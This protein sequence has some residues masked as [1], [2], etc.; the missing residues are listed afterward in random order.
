MTVLTISQDTLVMLPDGATGGTVQ[1]SYNG[2][3]VGPVVASGDD[4]GRAVIV[5][6]RL[7][8]LTAL[9]GK[10]PLQIAGREAGGRLP[11]R[12]TLRIYPAGSAT[13]APIILSGLPVGS[14]DAP[15]IWDLSNIDDASGGMDVITPAERTSLALLKERGLL[16]AE[17]AEGASAVAVAAEGKASAAISNLN[18]SVSSA[19]TQAAQQ[20]MQGTQ[21]E[22]ADIKRDTAQ[23]ASQLSQQQEGNNAQ[24]AMNIGRRTALKVALIGAAAGLY[25]VVSGQ[26]AGQ[27]WE[28]KE[29]GGAPVRR[30][31]L[32]AATQQQLGALNSP[33][34]D[35]ALASTS[36]APR[37]IIGGL[38]G[39]TFDLVADDTPAD[40]GIVVLRQ[41]GRKLRRQVSPDGVMA[42]EWWGVTPDAGDNDQAA[43]DAWSSYANAHGGKF[44]L[45]P[46]TEAVGHVKLQRPQRPVHI[47]GYGAK[48]I[49]TDTKRPVF[50]AY[51]AFQGGSIAGLM[52]RHQG[53]GTAP[54]ANHSDSRRT[55][56]G[57]GILITHGADW[58]VNSCM[59]SQVASMGILLI[60]VNG[61]TISNCNVDVCMGDGIHSCYGAA[62]GTITGNNVRFT[63]DD[64]IPVVS[65]LTW[66]ENDWN[67][68]YAQGGSAAPLC[69][70][71]TIVGNTV[72][73]AGSRGMIVAGGAR[74]NLTGN[75]VDTTYAAGI[76]ILKDDVYKTHGVTQVTL[77]GGQVYGAGRHADGEASGT[78]GISL[79]GDVAD[80]TV[81]GVMVSNAKGHGVY[82]EVPGSIDVRG[83]TVF[84]N[85]GDGLLAAQG[86]VQ[87]SGTF[88]GNG[89]RGVSAL[90]AA[91]LKLNG[92]LV[93]ENQQ[94]GV[95][96]GGASRVSLLNCDIEN[97]G[98]EAGDTQIE[99]GD[100]AAVSLVG[101]RVRGKKIYGVVANTGT[102]VRC[103][104][105]DLEGAG[106]E[107]NAV[108]AP[109]ATLVTRNC[110]GIADTPAA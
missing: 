44:A 102:S 64:G 99:A 58:A 88:R 4:Q 45:L 5:Q 33:D 74:I 93:Q 72:Q 86:Q 52:V 19:A 46:G 85:A 29:E 87:V 110:F 18:S 59:V 36:L 66:P 82:V 73:H 27:V 22:W 77:S 31:E 7:A 70:D 34:L 97:N 63:G 107:L 2:T 55:P 109:N 56:G 16:A 100:T 9:D 42:L 84:G 105:V 69:H 101:G 62:R 50:E 39:G 12:V 20:A 17:R 65:Y 37:H 68:D 57:H 92:A 51:L 81:D 3:T 38:R 41:D 95:G 90:G 104:G 91:L 98:V 8:K 75:I 53:I 10:S 96:A 43:L 108:A 35:A 47:V 94:V 15:G 21:R 103:L 54:P 106:T 40:G 32:E 13:V 71:I 1:I 83:V 48:L 78:H 79:I 30:P 11:A 67:L 61:Y 49:G 14:P 89:G 6:G 26:E 60:G 28:V 24:T 25:N 80:V 76:F 23:T